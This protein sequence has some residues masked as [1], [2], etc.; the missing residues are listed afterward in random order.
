MASDNV[1]PDLMA[2]HVA[3]GIRF[4][5]RTD[6]QKNAAAA[7]MGMTRAAYDTLGERMATAW[8]GLDP[9]EYTDE[10]YRAIFDRDK[11]TDEEHQASFERDAP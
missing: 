11:Y 8:T 7:D 3:A 2:E 10:Q 4:F 5:H 1:E 6:T 9:E